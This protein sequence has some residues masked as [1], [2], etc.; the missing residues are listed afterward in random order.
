MNATLPTG[1]TDGSAEWKLKG[2]ERSSEQQSRRSLFAQ[3]P[4]LLLGRL[5]F[6]RVADGS[7]SG[8]ELVGQEPFHIFATQEGILEIE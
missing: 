2:L 5:L 8:L 3:D 6:C 7:L 1:R 4:C